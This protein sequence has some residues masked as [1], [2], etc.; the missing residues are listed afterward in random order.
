MPTIVQGSTN[1]SA[2]SSL[3]GILYDYKYENGMDLRPAV[4]KLHKRIV[5]EVMK[6]ARLSYSAI[7]PRF[8][9]WR[10]QDALLTTYIDP[11][12]ED[13][14]AKAIDPDRPTRII[15]PYSHAVME[16]MLTYMSSAFFQD[17]IFRY[18]GTGPE[19][20]LGGALL[21]LV[22]QK[23][24]TRNK[25]PLALHTMFRDCF[26][27]GIG[28]VAP[29]W[30][31]RRGKR[32]VPVEV[33]GMTA[34]MNKV[35]GRKAAPQ[36]RTEETILFE[37]NILQNI[38]PYKVLPDP[39]VSIHKIQDGAFFGWVETVNL[40]KLLNRE[41]S[42]PSY[43]NVQYLNHVGG[44]TVGLGLNDDARNKKHK[45]SN[46]TLKD[47]TRQFEVVHIYMEI[48]PA[49]WKL[50][51]SV[52]P[53][54]WLFSVAA[55]EVVIQAKP[56]GLNHGMFPIAVAAP[57]YDGYSIAPMSKLETQYGLQTTLNWLF[58]S[59]ITNVRK[60]INDMLVVDPYMINMKDLENPGPGKLIR[61]R[62]PVWGRG[63]KDA[64]MQL[65]VQDVTRQHI[66]DASLIINW[67][68]NLVGTDESMMGSLRSGGPERLTKAEFSG[69]RQSSLTRL[70]HT[71]SVISMQAMHDIAYFFA[72]H[73]IQLMERET[74]VKVV[75]EWPQRLQEQFGVQP[76][77]KMAVRPDQLNIDYDVTIRDGSIPS[78][79][80]AQFWVE[81]F[82]IM[83]EHPELNQRFDIIRVFD[84][85]ARAHGEK[86]VEEF[87]RVMP[88]EQVQREVE[89][90]NLIPGN[91]NGAAVSQ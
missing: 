16:T 29:M 49:E 77:G 37:G 21:E 60:V 83:A 9:S 46:E 5:E 72:S 6:L 4:G 47:D 66:G 11:N 81:M 65:N 30:D 62:R 87:Y 88:D 52:Y 39:G 63:V 40:F 44:K 59:H 38:D 18:E 86:N 80:S 7:S 36:M 67:M 13:R 26:A 22:I 2:G 74:Y 25:I 35:L 24:C 33:G 34:T 68:N 53:E 27:Y 64:V 50:G 19:D 42:D 58:N 85:I 17:P 76:G 15:F 69:T 43:F 61:M 79:D 54:K 56:L 45:V 73:A 55:G 70:Q 51:P 84:K 57:D 48:I 12:D 90:G 14:K 1:G 82:G 8:S 71:A 32:Q 20:T 28:P 78:P 75:G 89:R 31:V 91:E 10:E 41:Y 3:S 23:H